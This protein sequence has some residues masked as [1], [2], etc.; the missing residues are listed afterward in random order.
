MFFLYVATKVA[1]TNPHPEPGLIDPHTGACA[2]SG[3]SM[4]QR[5]IMGD[6][7]PPQHPHVGQIHSVLQYPTPADPVQPRTQ[8]QRLKRAT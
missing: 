4:V 6:Y 1:H 2:L 8:A 3:A 7:S 5:A